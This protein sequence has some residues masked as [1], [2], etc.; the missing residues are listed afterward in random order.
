MDKGIRT[1]ADQLSERMERTYLGLRHNAVQ[2]CFQTQLCE[3]VRVQ[4]GYFGHVHATKLVFFHEI[5]LKNAIFAYHL[6]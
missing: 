2:Q 3:Y 4:Y 5:R 6:T 1:V